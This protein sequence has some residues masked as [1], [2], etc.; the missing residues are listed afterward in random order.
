VNF[1]PSNYVI[2]KYPRRPDFRS[3][4][5]WS[6]TVKTD[7]NGKAKV[8][9]YCSDD[10]GPLNICIDGLTKGRQLFSAEAKIEVVSPEK[11]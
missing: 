5:Y 7:S 2:N 6:P 11:K 3:T 1:T 9:F 10:I 8:E 4:I